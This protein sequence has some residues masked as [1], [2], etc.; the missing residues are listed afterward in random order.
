MNLCSILKKVIKNSDI[1]VPSSLLC[2]PS[3]SSADLSQPV[4]CLGVGDDGLHGHDGLIDLGLQLS[5][6]LDVQQAQDLS[7]LIQS[8]VWGESSFLRLK[9]P[10]LI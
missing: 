9:R 2:L 4:V 6:L 1:S 5:Q 10:F 7:R 3:S 8:C